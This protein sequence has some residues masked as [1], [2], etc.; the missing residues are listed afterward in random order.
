[1]RDPNSYYMN[2]D[3][4]SLGHTYVLDDLTSSTLCSNAC[5]GGVAVEVVDDMMDHDISSVV[6]RETSSSP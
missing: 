2:D 3:R 4:G 1:M 5:R 6:G